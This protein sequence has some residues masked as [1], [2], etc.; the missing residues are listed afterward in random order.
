MCLWFKVLV[1]SHGHYRAFCQH[2]N[3]S[4]SKFAA[5]SKQFHELISSTTENVK[6]IFTLKTVILVHWDPFP[7]VKPAI[8]DRHFHR[9]RIQT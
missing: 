3:A 8:I 5:Q 4:A 1:L 2:P 9:K 6:L 7:A